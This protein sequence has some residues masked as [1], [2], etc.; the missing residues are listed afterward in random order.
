MRRGGAAL[1]VVLF[2]LIPPAPAGPS[3]L[4]TVLDGPASTIWSSDGPRLIAAVDHLDGYGIRGNVSPDG[5]HLAYTRLAASGELWL[6]RLFDGAH[7][8]LVSDVDVHSAPVWSPDASRVTARRGTEVL[9]VSVQTGETVTAVPASRAQGVYPFAWHHDGLYYAVIAGGTAVYRDGRHLL[10]A[11][12]GIARDFRF[13]GDRLLYT[14]LNACRA[15][16]GPPPTALAGLPDRPSLPT[17][18]EFLGWLP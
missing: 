17:N 2:G 1:F 12:E 5:S 6:L 18:A 14:D 15:G 11:S 4:Y 16:A 13:E 8:H 7:R 10:R 9:S 3:F